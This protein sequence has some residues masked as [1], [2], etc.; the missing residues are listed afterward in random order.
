MRHRIFLAAPLAALTLHGCS[1]QPVPQ[2]DSAAVPSPTPATTAGPGSPAD[3]LT[4][5]SR[6][7]NARFD[8][9]AQL[10]PGFSADPAPANDDGRVFRN[11]LV[12]FR[13]SGSHNA[14][15]RAFAAQVDAATEGLSDVQEIAALP[16]YWRGTGQDSAGNRVWLMLARPDSS[17]LVT[18]RFAYPADRDAAFAATAERALK[19]VMLI[20]Q[21]G[22][23]GLRY[24]PAQ[25][26]AVETEVTLPP[27]HHQR[28][29]ALKLIARDRLDR[30]GE[31]A[32]RYGLSGREQRCTPGKEAGLAIAVADAPIGTI[33]SRIDTLRHQPSELAGRKGFRVVEGAEGQGASFAFVPL[34]ERTA[35]VERMWRGDRDGNGFQ[36]ALRS[37]EIAYGS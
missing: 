1:Q 29:D 19:G 23:V 10:P 11:G 16:G 28:H 9:V 34:G 33:R 30:I 2:D 3:P 12:E 26:A 37:I 25:H 24:D 20:A 21:Q 5:W 35:V 18:A 22:P 27:D 17:R 7:R 13:V 32:C 36:A 31:T 15:D 14:L 6:Y 8:F 4:D